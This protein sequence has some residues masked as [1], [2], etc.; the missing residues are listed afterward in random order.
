MEGEVV[1]GK[2]TKP[3][4]AGEMGFRFFFLFGLKTKA[5]KKSELD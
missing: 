5:H 1:D 3:H 4:L 2:K